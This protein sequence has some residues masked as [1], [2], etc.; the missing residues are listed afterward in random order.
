MQK[1]TSSFNLTVFERKTIVSGPINEL[2]IHCITTVQNQKHI[3][4][5]IVQDVKI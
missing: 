5:K 1:Q 2:E 4:T 3:F